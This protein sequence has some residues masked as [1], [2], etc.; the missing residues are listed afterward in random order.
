[1]HTKLVIRRRR[2][3]PELNASALALPVII[4]LGVFLAALLAQQNAGVSIAT[5]TEDAGTLA[6]TGWF[7]GAIST[8]GIC[9][10][11][12]STGLGF[13]AGNFRKRIQGGPRKTSALMWLAICSLLLLVDDAFMVH[14]TLAQEMPL[15]PE[16]VVQAG[17]GFLI[18]A[19][20]LVF[21]RAIGPSFVYAVP[22]LLCWTLSVTID[23]L[24]IE[25]NANA[26]LLEDGAKFMGIVLWFA[27]MHDLATRYF[28][29]MRPADPRQ[30][31]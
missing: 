14:E 16:A 4:T 24:G 29:A 26:V 19:T 25:N 18:I 17:I 27:L 2:V 15:L 30:T 7:A 31:D 6:E 8:V 23:M 20:L 22:A 13:F 11:A 1:M 5:L 10:L 12:A 21:I 9:L 28:L 3:L